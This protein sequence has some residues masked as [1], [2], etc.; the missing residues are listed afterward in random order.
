M[1][2]FS[3]KSLTLPVI[4]VDGLVSYNTLVLKQNKTKQSETRV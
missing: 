4:F 2:I 3:E 1:A